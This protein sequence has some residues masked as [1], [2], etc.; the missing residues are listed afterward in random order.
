[1]GKLFKTLIIVFLLLMA[2]AK[3]VE[4]INPS[5]REAKRAAIQA[6]QET[7]SSYQATKTWYDSLH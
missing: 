1:M 6:Y 7:G 4:M 3:V 2:V 5:Y